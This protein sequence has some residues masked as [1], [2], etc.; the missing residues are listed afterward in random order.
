[1][2]CKTRFITDCSKYFWICLGNTLSFF[3]QAAQKNA[4]LVGFGAILLQQ[5]LP[6][7]AATLPGTWAWKAGSPAAVSKQDWR[8]KQTVYPWS[9]SYSSKSGTCN[10]GI[11]PSALQRPHTT[12][13]PSLKASGGES[14]ASTEHQPQTTLSAGSWDS[15]PPF[16]LLKPR[17][18]FNQALK[19]A[20]PSPAM[21][22]RSTSKHA[23]AFPP[24]SP[25]ADLA[26]RPI[27]KKHL[28][29]CITGV[30]LLTFCTA[31]VCKK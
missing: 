13:Q 3:L 5:S 2:Y 24:S 19:P 1:M 10:S 8:R 15:L 28:C 23:L 7:T 22:K 20:P 25:C 12:V 27:Q 26:L 9:V 16:V 6:T 21:L 11:P 29:S 31:R 4:S 18:S 14:P 30:A 17:G